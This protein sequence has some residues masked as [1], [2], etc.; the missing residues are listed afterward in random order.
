[1]KGL[2]SIKMK[3]KLSKRPACGCCDDWFNTKKTS[4]Y[5]DKSYK[6]E[7][8][9]VFSPNLIGYDGTSERPDIVKLFPRQ[10]VVVWIDGP[11]DD[12]VYV[13]GKYF[14]LVEQWEEY[15]KAAESTNSKWNNYKDLEKIF[16]DNIDLL[17]T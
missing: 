13:D 17:Y 8:R 16:M 14:G 4:L 15:I 1:M 9:K 5:E 3:G 12:V 11:F 6:D 10:H 7:A 2:G